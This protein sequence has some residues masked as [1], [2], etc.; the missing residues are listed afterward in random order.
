MNNAAEILNYLHSVADSQLE[1]SALLEINDQIR[2]TRIRMRDP[3]LYLALVGEFSS[4]K[5]TFINALIGFRLLKEAVMPTTACATFIESGG[6]DLTADVIF[7]DGTRLNATSEDC[8]AL[9]Q[10]LYQNFGTDSAPL[11]EIIDM[12]TSDQAIARTVRRLHLIIP[13]SKLPRNIVLID[14]PGFNPGIDSADNH[15]EI[16]KFVVENIADAALILTPQEQAMSAT[17]SR[18]LNET[19]GRYIHRCLFVITKM[20]N[21]QAEFRSDTIEYVRQRIMADLSVPAPCVYA[22]SAVTMLPVRQI[23]PDKADEWAYF[24]NEFRQFET[25][26]WQKLQ[27]QKQIVVTEHLN[28]LLRESVILCSSR[29]QAKQTAVREEKEFLE[30]H[31]VENIRKV[32]DTMVSGSLDTIRRAFASLSLSFNSAEA[33]S[34]RQAAEIINDGEMN[35]SLFKDSMLPKI[36]KAIEE[37]ANRRLSEITLQINTITSHEISRELDKMCETFSSHYNGFPTL[38]PK[39]S[40]PRIDMP[41]LSTSGLDFHQAVNKIESLDKESDKTVGGGAV[42]GALLGALLGPVGAIIGAGLGA[43]AGAGIGENSQEMKTSA[44]PLIENDI[45]SYFSELLEKTKLEVS[46]FEQ[47]CM[48][49]VRQFADDHI[50]R[51]GEAVERMILLQEEEISFTDRQI[52]SLRNIL[53]NLGMIQDNIEQELA[54]LKVKL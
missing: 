41:R 9:N 35:M 7:Y 48:N 27:T 37:E 40:A 6:A 32:C 43:I 45:T 23:P 50:S 14:T 51:Y 20:D 38:K 16:T 13:D 2:K 4:G 3:R 34:R 42:G 10:Y 49:M 15:Y 29:I 21:L 18:F 19:L 1:G 30:N 11:K 5:S 52:K 22:E 53:L 39:V 17:L 25:E 44:K 33:N 28:S 47:R 46:S 12:L 24:Q 31:R 36:R 26:I 8:Q 54:I